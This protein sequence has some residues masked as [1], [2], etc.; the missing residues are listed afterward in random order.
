MPSEPIA[1]GETRDVLATV[2]RL[3]ATAPDATFNMF[4]GAGV[5]RDPPTNGPIWNEM[6][7]G[8]LSAAFDRME[9]A[10]WTIADRFP[11]DRVTA[12]EMNIRPEVFW[13]HMLEY[14]GEHV[15]TLALRAADAGTPN[16]NHRL[17]AHLLS[18][19]RCA[20][21]IT[22]NFD[23]HVE[24]LLSSRVRVEV[25]TDSWEVHSKET[26]VLTKLHGS[27][28]NTASLVYTLEQYDVLEP[29]N[30]RIIK[31]LAN[32]PLLIA[33]YSGYDTDVLPALSEAVKHLP[34]TVIVKHPGANRSQP[35]FGLA[36]ASS[37][38]IVVEANCQEV[39]NVI[40]DGQPAL[41][42]GLNHR[43]RTTQPPTEMQVK[44]QT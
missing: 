4:F 5:S 29:R 8:L 20:Y 9:R 44:L 38:V 31:R 23:E 34:L 11:R 13:R 2:G 17:I 19:G 27:S 21:A 24:P 7:V 37:S 18:S 25:P 30:T 6:Q 14:V 39:L 22:T 3:R 12:A 10:N 1:Y 28:S 16:Q 15:V 40:A 42:S 26:S 36:K 33:G 43:Q 35:V 41:T 32:R